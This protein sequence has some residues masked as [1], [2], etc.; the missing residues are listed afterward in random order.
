MKTRIFS[1]LVLC[2]ALSTWG[3]LAAA[4]CTCT[5][6]GFPTAPGLTA[7]QINPTPT[8]T[9][10]I[11]AAACDI[12]V[13]YS[14]G[15][16]GSVN[17]ATISGGGS[18]GVLV[19]GASVDVLNSTITTPGGVG[20]IYLNGASC[21]VPFRQRHPWLGGAYPGFSGGYP[22]ACGVQ[23]NAI[24]LTAAGKT[25]VVAK[26]PG[27][28]VAIINNMVTGSGPNG[29][30]AQNGIEIGDGAAAD[31]E[32]NIVTNN[33][34]T[35]PTF[36]ATGILIYGGPAEAGYGNF[37]GPNYTSHLEVANNTLSSNDLGVVLWNQAA[38]NSKPPPTNNDVS[39]ND[40][41]NDATGADCNPFAT[42][43]AYYSGNGD[44]TNDNAVY[45]VCY[46]G[47]GTVAPAAD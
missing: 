10:T 45:G 27:T 22:S 36:A 33:E 3:G 11:N 7:C 28:V 30:I 5:A 19:N 40:I 12:G 20:I 32:R 23:N 38:G 46:G 21:L 16:S 2:G 6:T 15:N 14:P 37:E 9:G 34:Y 44:T 31:I 13:Y 43:I 25:G 42:G 29:G 41:S 47:S 18:F 26:N 39:Q 8:V 4:A 17:G 35:G 1:V 24:T